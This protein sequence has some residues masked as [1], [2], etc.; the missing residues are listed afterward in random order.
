MRTRWSAGG[1][2][3]HVMAFVVALA[4]LLIFVPSAS[5]QLEDAWFEGNLSYDIISG[6]GFTPYATVTVVVKAP[7]DQL[8][9]DMVADGRLPNA[10]VA[11]SIMMQAQHA[12]LKALTNHLSDLVRRNVITQQTM[13]EILA[14]VAEAPGGTVVYSGSALVDA[15]GRFE[16]VPGVDLVPEMY[17]SVTEGSFTRELTLAVLSI[18]ALSPDE[19][20]VTG[21]APPSATFW[22]DADVG[23]EWPGLEVTSDPN[24]DWTA[25]FDDIGVDI[26]PYAHVGASISDE[27]G[28][29]TAFDLQLMGP[30]AFEVHRGTWPGVFFKGW[31]VGD[32]LE[33]TID[34]YAT[35]I[36]A[37]EPEEGLDGF[38]IGIDYD[39]RPGDVVTVTDVTDGVTTKSHTVTAVAVTAV[40]I[41]AD[42]AYGTAL[43][44]TDLTVYVPTTELWTSAA[45][46]GTWMADF[47]SFTDIV[48]GT[49]VS[50]EQYDSDG[51][52]TV[53]D[54]EAPMTLE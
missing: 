34:D 9:D 47:S 25:D 1:R 31:T 16:A 33:L 5:A 35:T 22:L 50:A 41:A 28:D 2:A 40:D 24:G 29:Q 53:Y 10:G 4:A 26:T 19:N 54:F 7:L 21:T 20:T 11:S 46:D 15:L 6:S 17:I 43:P 48:P 52:S 36:I 38:G 27:D 13:N 30:P 37:E 3:L 12:P 18:D 44:G 23:G 45:D 32:T 8:L 39:I 14:G 49:S 42:V 51:D